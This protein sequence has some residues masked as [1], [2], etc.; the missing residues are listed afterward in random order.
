MA[1]LKVPANETEAIKSSLMSLFE[2]RR[3]ANLYKYVGKVD[4]NDKKTW[5]KIDLEK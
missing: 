3:V 5:G 4:K 2:K 1:V